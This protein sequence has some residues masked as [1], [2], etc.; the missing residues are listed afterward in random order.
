MANTETKLVLSLIG[1]IM[2][3]LPYNG[4]PLESIEMDPLIHQSIVS[5]VELSRYRLGP[6]CRHLVNQLENIS[7]VLIAP[8]L[9]PS[10]TS[11]TLLLQRPCLRFFCFFLPLLRRCVNTSPCGCGTPMDILALFTECQ[12]KCQLKCLEAPGERKRGECLI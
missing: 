11:C 2:S 8:S 12:L 6:I 4:R 9:H 1:R 10:S 7:K 3:K 5:L